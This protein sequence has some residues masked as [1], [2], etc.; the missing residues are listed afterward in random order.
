MIGRHSPASPA[1]GASSLMGPTLV[2][3]SI[4]GQIVELQMFEPPGFVEDLYSL[5]FNQAEAKIGSILQA[6]RSDEYHTIVDAA[7]H[8]KGSSVSVG[9]VE[10]SEL[11]REVQSRCKVNDKPGLDSTIQKLLAAYLETK[12][13]IRSYIESQALLVP[14]FK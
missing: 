6:A 8:L 9:A 11:C 2:D 3:I 10:I 13:T 1:S 7:Q 14:S 4:V 12:Q 5:F